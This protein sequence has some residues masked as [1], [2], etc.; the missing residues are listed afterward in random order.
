A[1]RAGRGPRSACTAPAARGGGRA[2]GGRLRR[3][4]EHPPARLRARRPAAG[5]RAVRGRRRRARAAG[6]GA[7]V[8]GRARPRTRVSSPP[9]ARDVLAL[10]RWFLRQRF[11]L[12]DQVDRASNIYGV[13]FAIALALILLWP[14]I[15]DVLPQ[16][17]APSLSPRVL[18]V[19]G[20]ALLL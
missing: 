1:R 13:L 14:V 17:V 3:G 7:R 2:P 10:R 18:T 11:T 9:A 19:A 6:G 4:R 8:R 20:P 5:A 12:G 16:R 15:G